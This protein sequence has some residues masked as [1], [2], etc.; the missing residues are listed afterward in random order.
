MTDLGP[1]SDKGYYFLLKQLVFIT[2]FSVWSP[3]K[4]IFAFFP[5][6]QNTRKL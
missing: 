2:F 5:T 3:N 4:E 1:P 6:N